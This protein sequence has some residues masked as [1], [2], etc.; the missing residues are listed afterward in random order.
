MSGVYGDF[1]GAF[2][3]LANQ[4]F[5]MFSVVPKVG[6]GY[7]LCPAG[8]VVGYVQDSASYL[9]VAGVRANTPSS[10]AGTALPTEVLYLYTRT[11]IPIGDFFIQVNGAYYRPDAT[12]NFVNEG[13]LVIT[14]L[15]KVTGFSEQSSAVVLTEG[16]FA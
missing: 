13:A 14:T 15:V 16:E 2:S 9:S 12:S 10:K 6:G 1:L 7:E 4:T 8:K 11:P 3:E 5:S